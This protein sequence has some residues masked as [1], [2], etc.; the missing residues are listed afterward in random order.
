MDH[1]S[2][3]FRKG[4][5]VYPFGLYFGRQDD[6]EQFAKVIK[7]TCALIESEAGVLCARRSQTMSQPG[8]WEFPGGKIEEG[9]TEEACLIR[10]IREE[11]GVDV[12]PV[13]RLSGFPYT[14]ANGFALELIPF[15]CRILSGRPIA[16]EHEEIRWIPRK[17]LM[18]LDWAA[19]DIPVV[20]DYLTRDQGL[21]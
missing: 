18:D 8:K 6:A 2:E 17:Y 9:E 16:H 14:Y 3:L 11:L 12:H 15:R 21:I 4:R 13:E 10:E 1:W 7:V 19:A 20:Q 5:T